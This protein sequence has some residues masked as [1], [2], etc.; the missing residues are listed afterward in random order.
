M[1]LGRERF[2]SQPL[3]TH[4]VGTEI[5]T[6]PWP[7]GAVIRLAVTMTCQLPAIGRVMRKNANVP[8][9]RNTTPTRFVAG[10]ISRPFG[11]R[12]AIWNVNV[13]PELTKRR[14]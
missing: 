14:S 1:R 4:F 2:P 8:P 10:V 5:V 6:W 7:R 11:S 13:P 3:V 9:R 12:S